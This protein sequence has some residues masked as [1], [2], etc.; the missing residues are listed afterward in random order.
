MKFIADLHIHSP[1]SRATSKDSTLAGLYR[2]ALVKGINVIGTGDFT[3]PGWL[4]HLKENLKPAEPGLYR[5]ANE[6]LP[7]A[8]EDAAP[9][10]IPVRFMLSAEISSIYKKEGRVRK[11]H[12]ILY[13]PDFASVE[14]INARLAAVGNIESDGRPILGLD[15][16]LLLEIMLEEAP[17]GFLVPAHI[18]TPWFSL[19]G[20]KSGFDR[21]EDCFGDLSDHI[22]ALETGLSSD[23]DMNR[24][25][26]ALDRYTLISN[27]DCHSP[28]K[29]GREAN[30]FETDLDYFSMRRALSDPARG[31]RGT[32]EFFPE[33]GK[34]HHDGHRKC[35]VSLDPVKTRQLEAICPECHRPVTVGVLH[36]VMELADRNEP[37]YAPEAPRVVSL[38]P[39]PEVLGEIMGRG[40]ATKGVMSQY[41]KVIGAFG[42]EFTFYMHTPLEEIKAYSTVLG[43]AVDRIRNLK[44][45]R[46]AGFDGEFGIISVFEEG[47]LD[48]LAGQTSMFGAPL[49]RR[50]NEPRNR[51]LP[52]MNTKT[53]AQEQSI[54]TA[55]PQ[56]QQIIDSTADKI[57]VA[58]GPGTGKTFTLVE[59]IGS[60]LEKSTEPGKF[61]A[62]TFTN[63]AAA[64]I[65]QRLLKKCDAKAG[66]VFTGTCHSFCLEWL[67][68]SKPGL[69][70]TGEDSRHLLLK[71]LFPDAG[72][73]ERAHI[74]EEISRYFNSRAT[75]GINNEFS[76]SVKRYQDALEIENR[77]DLDDIIPSFVMMLWT[78][79][80]F[81]NCVQQQVKFLFV[82]E[83]QDINRS[84]YELVDILGK[85]ATV[86]VIGDPDQ[87]IYGF[88]GSDLRFFLDYERKSGVAKYELSI[89]YR[90]APEIL[91]AAGQMIAHNTLRSGIGLTPCNSI[92]TKI[93]LHEAPTPEAEAE[94]I[95]RRIEE[96]IGGISS[97]SLNT[98]RGGN[99]QE[100]IGF[101]DIAVLYRTNRQAGHIH[102]ALERRGIPMQVVGVEPF[103]MRCG[104]KPLYYWIQIAAG[105]SETADY[106]NFLSDVPGFGKTLLDRLE[107]SLPL[108]GDFFAAAQA[109]VKPG[110]A[111]QHLEKIRDLLDRFITD[112]AKSSIPA[113]LQPVLE[114][115]DVDIDEEHV[116]RFRDLAGAFGNDLAPL[117]HHL[118]ARSKATEYDD[119]IEAVSLLTLHAAKG[120]EFPV[121]FIAGLEDGLVPYT[122]AA[123]CD[124]EE[125]RRLFYVGITRAEQELVLT[126]SRTRPIFGKYERQRSRFLDEFEQTLLHHEK[127][128]VLRKS[129]PQARQM[130]LF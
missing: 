29:L 71:K 122:P 39:L 121:T 107:T 44:V 18:W 109:I 38:I 35:N 17:E 45:I 60:L 70:V 12:N 41:A 123:G 92:S 30:L 62:I 95:V 75:G 73:K 58:A 124:I 81:C 110:A 97:F 112:C 13:V 126:Y 113:A 61:I 14:R 24:L 4:A 127:M 88:R 22:F 48:T 20:S 1:F 63:R 3:H 47:E 94:F 117:A 65:K 11:I 59:R 98:G 49:K 101:R 80:A 128:P 37:R 111:T 36:R 120:L 106:L 19:F 42:S 34:Y 8:L 87:A 91:S 25:I 119:N 28:A 114:L 96:S 32:V 82:D 104:L 67:R 90:S 9:A 89:N 76:E 103:F 51:T 129:K 72:R 78:D 68:K 85:Q 33:E 130:N 27:S 55:N 6:N 125:E 108:S 15:S 116:K 84:Q 79:N 16:R 43:E 40:P 93:T 7:P 83:F 64:E 56:Q 102:Q 100:T 105:S 2:W 66:A 118:A 21:L 57:I 10:G 53:S 77:I 26:S 31:F 23:P 50:K 115:L 74:S 52:V 99:L 54:R 69:T 46:K 86:C 5:L